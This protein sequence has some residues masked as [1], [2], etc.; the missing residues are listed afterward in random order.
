MNPLV[1]VYIT[2]QNRPELLERSL[3]SLAKQTYRNFE[4]LICND[5]SSIE[6]DL[7][8][9]AIIKK[10][11][12]DF[13]NLFYHKN[14]VVRGACYSRNL[15]I[16]HARGVYITGLDDDDVF[17]E[18]R[19][20]IFLN[21]SSTDNYSFLCSDISI[22]NNN[23][24]SILDGNGQGRIINFDDMKYYNVVGNQIFVKRELISSVGGFDINMPAW[25]DYDTWFRLIKEY[26]PAFKLNDVTM[27]LD[28]SEERV[29]ITTSSKAH[30][31]YKMFVKKHENDLNLENKISLKYMDKINRKVNFN[32]FHLE[33]LKNPK[34]FI[35]VFKYR[36]VYTYPKIYSIYNYFK[37]SQYRGVR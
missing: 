10:H 14:D 24:K 15:L 22:L 19:L 18:E 31:G 3:M 9:D 8:Y 27:Y 20:T 4:V 23:A 17:H 2:T 33:L 35:N 36:A 21:F 25:Q 37:N 5:A 13:I 29:R 34:V 28:S 30:L 32:P 1:S 12:G 16:K 26:G 6:Y 7:R 11:E